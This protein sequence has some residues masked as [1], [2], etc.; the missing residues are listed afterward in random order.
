MQHRPQPRQD[1]LYDDYFVQRLVPDDHQLVQIDRAVDFSFVRELVADLYSPD[2]GREAVDPELLLRLCFLQQLYGLSDRDVISRGTTDLA[3]RVFLHLGVEESLPHPSLLSVFRARLGEER[4]R[5]IFNRSVAVAVERG[6]VKGRLVIMDSYG[7]VADVAIP[8][9]RRLLQRVSRRGLLALDRLGMDTQQSWHEYKA[10]SE[11]NSWTQSTE[12][13]EKNLQAWFILTRQV[14]EALAQAQ[15]TGPDEQ[16][17]TRALNLLD[18][19]LERQGMP[20][21]KRPPDGLVS[22]V[23]PDARWGGK[24]RG[25]KAFVGYKEQISTDAANEIITGAAATP[26]NVDDTEALQELVRQHM[27]NVGGIPQGVAAD[28]GYSSG[29]N[30]R[31]LAQ[32]GI[33]D[34]IAVPTPKGHKQGMFSASD[35]DV[36]WDDDGAPTSVR[37]PATQEAT[38]GKWDDKEQGWT[39]YFTKGQCEGCALR[40]RCSKS[41]RGRTV[42]VS[43]YYHEHARAQA[44]AETE[45]FVGA[46]V[47][48]LA[49]ERT[50][51]Y[52]QRR[53]GHKRARYRGLDRVAIQVLLSSFVLNVVRIARGDLSMGQVSRAPAG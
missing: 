22:D 47:G 24:K 53:C 16:E 35:F 14:R 11:D 28:S 48:R 29:P 52:K 40:A 32:E 33:E 31:R 37:C 10:L 20:K 42:F 44:R 4:F 6:L 50:F 25:K 51:A 27:E 45:E 19:A 23:D 34:F 49:I 36:T 12:L 41:K 1:S 2:Q 13:R 7:I 18:K 43:G 39:F 8:R 15:A 38:G 26:G 21:G 9:T 17:R 5:E 46:Q 30:R 3:F